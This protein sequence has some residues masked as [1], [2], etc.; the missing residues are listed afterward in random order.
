MKNLYGYFFYSIYKL[1]LRTPG[2]RTAD[3]AAVKLIS[4]AQ[5]LCTFPLIYF[6]L[7]VLPFTIEYWVSAIIALCYA[8]ALNLVNNRYFIKGK[9]L[10]RVIE[11]FKNETKSEGAWRLSIVI[12]AWLSTFVVFFYLLT[13]LRT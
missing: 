3:D 2:K 6:L 7:Q 10:Q 4:I 13:L 11:V 12:V 5:F 9:E 1:M 8:F